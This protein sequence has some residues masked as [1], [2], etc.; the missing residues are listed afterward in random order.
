MA[1]ADTQERS[2]AHEL[3]QP[4]IEVSVRQTFGIDMDMTVPGFSKGSEYV[5]DIDNANAVTGTFTANGS[6]LAGSFEL[7]GNGSDDIFTFNSNVETSGAAIGAFII[8]NASNV[9]FADDADVTA[10]T[11]LTIQ[12]VG[13]DVQL[14][15]G[16]DLTAENGD[17]DLSN[18]TVID[19][20][21]AGS[22][23]QITA[24]GS[25]IRLAA[26]ADSGTGVTLRIDADD[27]V[28]LDTV[29]LDGDELNCSVCAGLDENDPDGNVLDPM[30]LQR[31]LP[32]SGR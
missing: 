22:T 23:N 2:R 30:D 31:F 14:G 9:N 16:A 11:N 27:S 15:S 17:V 25:E 19:L 4:D 12:N 7:S 5:P 29:T 32:L 10:E 24:Q 18:V 26:I 8:D 6:F 13:G 28:T 3:D 1:T 21:G 20:A